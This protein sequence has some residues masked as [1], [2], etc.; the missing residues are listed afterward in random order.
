MP[1]VAIPT[2]P[3]EESRHSHHDYGGSKGFAYEETFTFFPLVLRML[4][5]IDGANGDHMVGGKR[6]DWR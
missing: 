5:R 4:P 1:Q 3:Y 6:L 2:A